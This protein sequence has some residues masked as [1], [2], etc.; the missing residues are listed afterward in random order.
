MRP[1]GFFC[2]PY[3]AGK[4]MTE[5]HPEKDRIAIIGLGKVG[6]A[7]GHLLREADTESPPSSTRSRRQSNSISVIPEAAGREAPPTPS[8]MP[9]PC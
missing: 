7:V 4:V 1:E 5:E 9:I 6:T 3:K 2:I 8:G